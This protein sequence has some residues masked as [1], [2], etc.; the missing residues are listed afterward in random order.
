MKT[1]P[2]I[3]LLSCLILCLLPV[4]ASAGDVTL[5]RDKARACAACHGLDGLSRQ[6]D[7]PN[8]AGQ[9][10]FYMAHQLKQYQT[11][12][13]QHPQMSVIAQGLTDEDIADLVAYYSAI[14]IS[15]TLPE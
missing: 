10:P 13:R 14:E 8:L 15:V 2:F 3:L 5:G 6:P 7:S 9:N 1:S 12:R 11:G 4:A